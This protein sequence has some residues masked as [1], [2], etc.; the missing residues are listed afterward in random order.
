MN[1][2]HRTGCTC[3]SCVKIEREKA[4]ACPISYTSYTFTVKDRYGAPFEQLKP[5]DGYRFT[6]E[7]RPT[8]DSELYMSVITRGVLSEVNA[9]PV[10]ILR[11]RPK[12]K[13]II[14][15]ETPGQCSS[16]THVYGEGVDGM[17]RATGFSSAKCFTRREEEF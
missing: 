9:L 12:R 5:P 3:E 10:L 11:P 6:G 4:E 14:F 16:N 2:Y 17:F 7:F 1:R 8:L 13:R 15:E